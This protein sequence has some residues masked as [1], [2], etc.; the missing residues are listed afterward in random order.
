MYADTT[1]IPSCAASSHVQKYTY[2]AVRWVNIGYLPPSI[3]HVGVVLR[4][5]NAGL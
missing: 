2:D 4:M 3:H 5:T 1:Y